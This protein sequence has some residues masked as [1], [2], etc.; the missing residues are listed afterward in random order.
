[1][2]TNFTHRFYVQCISLQCWR[3]LGNFFLKTLKQKHNTTL[4]HTRSFQNP[5]FGVLTCPL[6]CFYFAFYQIRCSLYQ[7][8]GLKCSN[9][10]STF[11][12]SPRPR[13]KIGRYGTVGDVFEMP[14]TWWQWSLFWVCILKFELKSKWWHSKLYNQTSAHTTQFSLNICS[15]FL[16]L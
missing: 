7:W 15:V 3:Q 10:W 1:M 2:A 16:I 12:W 14:I 6:P 4:H 13:L 8:M 5:C 9:F 11:K